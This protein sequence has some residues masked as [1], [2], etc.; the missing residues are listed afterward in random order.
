MMIPIV[1]V[2]VVRNMVLTSESKAAILS[3]PVKLLPQMC[4]EPVRLSNIH[5][6]VIAGPGEDQSTA[7]VMKLVMLGGE[8]PV[9]VKF[10]SDRDIGNKSV[11]EVQFYEQAESASNRAIAP[12]VSVYPKD[13][14]MHFELRKGKTEPQRVGLPGVVWGKAEEKKNWAVK[15]IND[16]MDELTTPGMKLFARIA[17]HQK[18]HPLNPHLFNCHPRSLLSILLLHAEREIGVE[19]DWW[20]GVPVKRSFKSRVDAQQE[21]E[22]REK[23]SAT[24]KDVQFP[25][26]M[27]PMVYAKHGGNFFKGHLEQ[28]AAPSFNRVD[29]G[30][31]YWIVV[32]WSELAKMIP[33]F[34]ELL[35]IK[36]P[37]LGKRDL[38]DDE[39]A[40]LPTIL[41]SRELFIPPWM[42][43]KYGIK[44]WHYYQKAGDCMVLDGYSFHQGTVD[45][46]NNHAYA[47]AVN[48]LDIHWLSEDGGLRVVFEMCKWLRKQYVRL[49]LDD[50]ASI[51]TSIRVLVFDQFVDGITHFLPAD[52]GVRF[53]EVLEEDLVKWID[54]DGTASDSG[55]LFD[56]DDGSVLTKVAGRVAL[57][58]LRYC[59]ATMKR[60]HVVWMYYTSAADRRA[61]RAAQMSAAA[62]DAKKASR[63]EAPANR[64]QQQSEAAAFEAACDEDRWHGSIFDPAVVAPSPLAA[65]PPSRPSH[66]ATREDE[67]M[68]EEGSSVAEQSPPSP[69]VTPAVVKPVALRLETASKSSSAFKPLTP[70]KRAAQSAGSGVAAVGSSPSKRRRGVHSS[71]E[72]ETEKK[73]LM[74]EAC[75][76]MHLPL[77]K[78]CE[79]CGNPLHSDEC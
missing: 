39:V 68:R 19:V 6:Y 48:F 65:S 66:S 37:N 54:G 40:L 22:R 79:Q 3:V 12:E 51:H 59:L 50:T 55:C 9:T 18:C 36:L 41:L 28:L 56:Y 20:H 47:E 27:S 23:E 29:I 25:G 4:E 38:T 15:D 71:S 5:R 32:P 69:L 7:H 63:V 49:C 43:D 70:G 8:K 2:K 1:F 44:Y 30:G 64:S 75:D 62:A 76:H 72:G 53:L 61:M 60:Q 45:D 73:T 52:W 14:E 11:R 16:N 17:V 74:C 13:V 46:V 31:Q 33:L 78:A 34:E 10:V 58:R 42:L 57:R 77:T 24:I 67:Q 26:F 35:R 21:A